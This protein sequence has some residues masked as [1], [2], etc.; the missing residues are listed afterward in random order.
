MGKGLLTGNHGD[1]GLEASK[2]EDKRA[3]AEFWGH[4]FDLLPV[5]GE[6]CHLKD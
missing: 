4:G 5:D 6:C 3:E 2:R 1:R